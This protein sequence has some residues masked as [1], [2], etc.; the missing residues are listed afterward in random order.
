MPPT[1]GF[2]LAALPRSPEIP[3]KIGSIDAREIY[4]AV[5]AGLQSAEMARSAPTRA[6]LADD[7]AKTLLAEG[8][9]RR[10]TLPALTQETIDS[11]PLRTRLLAAN[12]AG[13]PIRNNLLTTQA[14]AATLN[15]GAQTVAREREAGLRAQATKELPLLLQER[16]AANQLA[17]YHETAAALGNLRVKYPWIALPEFKDSIA[18][19]LD[20]EQQAAL[21]AAQAQGEQESRERIATTRGSYSLQGT[22]AR[23]EATK[24]A[25]ALR[26]G[27]PALLARE[28]ELLQSLAEFPDDPNIAA[29]LDSVKAALNRVSASE[30]IN[31]NAAKTATPTAEYYRK[32]MNRANEALAAAT[33]TL[34]AARE[35]DDEDEVQ[36]A[37]SIYER[38]KAEAESTRKEYELYHAERTKKV[39]KGI[40]EASIRNLAAQF[41]GKKVGGTGAP[42][43]AAAVTPAPAAQGKKLTPEKA[44]E[45]LQ[46]AGGDKD[47]AR[48][49]ARKDG[50]SF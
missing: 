30:R 50:W 2:T 29:Q 24:T 44:V 8:D 21:K 13:A 9:A 33:E 43:P 49:L 15:L 12:V 1:S 28:A 23:A 22:Q 37:Q 5:R 3:A 32:S 10:T 4:D 6:V 34:D 41:A 45:F 40:D 36:M 38:A 14:Q 46:A 18:K 17:G 16:D 7:Q 35:T 26:G 42:T 47:K 48:E 19:S 11:A 25:A 31:P 27:T 39:S 20:E